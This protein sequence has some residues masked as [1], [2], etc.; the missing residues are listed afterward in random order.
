M[1]EKKSIDILKDLIEKI[2]IPFVE[3]EAY[4]KGL[5]DENGFLTKDRHLLESK[6]NRDCVSYSHILAWNLRRMLTT[7]HVDGNIELTLLATVLIK[8]FYV[9]NILISVN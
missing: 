6:N 7:D 2:S 1:S 4:K 5:I 3:T 8:V 9:N